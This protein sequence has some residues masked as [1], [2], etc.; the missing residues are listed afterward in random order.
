[1][2]NIEVFL[3]KEIIEQIHKISDKNLLQ[4]ANYYENNKEKLKGGFLNSF[5]EICKKSIKI[6]KDNITNITYSMIGTNLARGRNTYLIEASNRVGSVDKDSIKS[7][8][9][10]EWAFKYFDQFKE[11]LNEIKEL[12]KERIKNY[13]IEVIK[14][15]ESEKYNQY[16]LMLARYSLKDIEKLKEFKE[17]NISK[18][19]E[20]RVENSRHIFK[21]AYKKDDR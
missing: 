15:N 18:K 6:E 17:L 5:K 21:I 3:D 1:M 16:I 13:Q 4:L 8:Y 14:L 9:N 19:F 12:Y 10:V 11:E 7:R 20:I 2:S